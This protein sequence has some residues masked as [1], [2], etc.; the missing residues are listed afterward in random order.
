MRRIVAKLAIVLFALVSWVAPAS[1][2]M[3]WCKSDPVVT[4]NNAIVDVSVAIPLEYVPLVNG[5]VQYEI[6]TPVF[7]KRQV[8]LNDVGYNGHGS[9]V[10]FKDGSGTVQDGQIP[11]TVRVYIPIDKQRLAPGEVVPAELTVIADDV[12][13]LVE[14]GTSSQL[15]VNTLITERDIALLQ[16]SQ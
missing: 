14:Q 2:G 15:T 10:I 16:N 8:I 5:P 1:A 9:K 12:T 6:Q 3:T 7:T 13:V 4:L 11:T